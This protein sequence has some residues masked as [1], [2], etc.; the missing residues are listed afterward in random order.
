MIDSKVNEKSR[1]TLEAHLQETE[2]LIRNLNEVVEIKNNTQL[3]SSDN[4]NHLIE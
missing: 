4:K 2:I 1:R 3:Q